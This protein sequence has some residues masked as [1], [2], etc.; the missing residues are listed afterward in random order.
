[1]RGATLPCSAAIGNVYCTPELAVQKGLF[2]R[3]FTRRAEM[4]GAFSFDQP[5]EPSTSRRSIGL[6]VYSASRPRTSAGL[7]MGYVRPVHCT[8]VFPGST[9]PQVVDPGG[10]PGSGTRVR[11]PGSGLP[12]AS[13]NASDPEIVV[14]RVSKSV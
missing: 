2:W 1:M 7:L 11:F 8:P 14:G 10:P 3:R 5:T 4:S 6:I 9:A 12:F 13:S